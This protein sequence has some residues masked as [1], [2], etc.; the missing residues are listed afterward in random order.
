MDLVHDDRFVVFMRNDPG[1]GDRPDCAER[2]LI[3]CATY[4]EARRVQREVL[5]SSRLCVIR[6]IGPAGG[7]D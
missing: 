6:F 5:S 1:C 2:P 4:A 7:G 3:T